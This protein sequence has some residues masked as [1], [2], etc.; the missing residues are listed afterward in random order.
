MCTTPV[1]ITLGYETS[2]CIN[3]SSVKICDQQ[4]R[5][6]HPSRM[7]QN[8]YPISEYPHGVYYAIITMRNGEIITRRF[9]L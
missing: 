6:H 8:S 2:V 5:I 7:D 9:I 1:V 3:Y 4:G